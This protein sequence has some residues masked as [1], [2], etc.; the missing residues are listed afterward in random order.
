MPPS[1][2]TALVA[3]SGPK[4]RPRGR[5]CAASRSCA[6]PGCTR[7]VSAVDVDDAA[8]EAGE[9]DHQSRAERFAG[10]AA[11]GPAGVD[12]DALFRGVLQAG[13]RVRRPPRPHHG[14]RLDLV[15]ARV[16]RVKLQRDL[17]AT[18]L[19]RDQS[20]QVVLD[21]R[22]LLMQGVHEAANGGFRK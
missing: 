22:T 14:Q 7:T 20:A 16:G 11:A 18:D 5:N 1:V 8:E 17:V 3:G 12:G 2:A 21:S 19:A 15:N 4:Q 13:R 10:G 9:V 6:I